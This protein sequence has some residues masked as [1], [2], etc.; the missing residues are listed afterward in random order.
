MNMAFSIGGKEKLFAGEISINI[1]SD[2]KANYLGLTS[3]VN[4]ERLWT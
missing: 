4:Y 2:R 3:A 1:Y